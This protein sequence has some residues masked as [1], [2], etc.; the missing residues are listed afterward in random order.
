MDNKRLRELAG[1]P[2]EEDSVVEVGMLVEMKKPQP[3]QSFGTNDQ[4]PPEN[5]TPDQLSR[6]ADMLYCAHE[7][8]GKELAQKVFK[9]LPGSLKGEFNYAKWEYVAPKL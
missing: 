1:L 9:L 6:A 4:A 3:G 5:H 7:V 2:C 8:G